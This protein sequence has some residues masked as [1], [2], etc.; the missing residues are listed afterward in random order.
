MTERLPLPLPRLRRTTGF[1]LIEL[2]VSLLIMSLLAVMAWGGIDSLV[3]SREITQSHNDHVYALRMGISQWKLD[4]DAFFPAPTLLPSAVDWDGR[5]LRILRRSATPQAD[6]SDVG[7]V[8]VGW[9]LREGQW[10]RWQSVDLIKPEAVQQAWQQ[11]AQWGQNPSGELRQQ[12]ARIGSIAQ[13]RILYFR[14]NAWSNPLSSADNTQESVD[15]TAQGIRLELYLPATH[16]QN[17]L[18]QGSLPP[19]SLAGQGSL[20]LDWAAPQWQAP[21]T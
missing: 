19:N 20:V 3:R 16:S 7:L 8:V 12:E 11:V 6:G 15:A 13:W 5:V 14:N 4:L 2:L 21:R 17:A 9:T 1:T 18:M 10:L